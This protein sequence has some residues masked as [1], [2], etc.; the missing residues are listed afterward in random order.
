MFKVKRYFQRIVNPDHI[1]IPDETFNW[2]QQNL[3][4]R[5]SAPTN[6]R[7]LNMLSFFFVIGV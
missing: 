2:Q 5:D 4:A 3:D 7:R 1:D 6:V